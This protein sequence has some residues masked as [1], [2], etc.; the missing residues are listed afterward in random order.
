[1]K[2][3][4][5]PNG[6]KIA[7]SVM[8]IKTFRAATLQEGLR[9]IHEELGEDVKIMHTREVE[10]S[11]LF[12]FRRQR[13][14]EI[15]VAENYGKTTQQKT[16]LSTEQPLP[17]NPYE[18]LLAPPVSPCFRSELRSTPA[19]AGIQTTSR[20]AVPLG[21][22]HQLTPEQLNPTVL[23]RSLIALFTESVRFGGPIDLLDGK[24]K[25]VAFLGMSGVGKTT[26]I[27]KIAAH[28][29]L[30]EF[31]RVGLVT[32][33]TFR[34][35]AT[36][37]LGKYAEMLGLPMEIVSEPFRMKTALTRLEACD[38]ILLDTPGINPKNTMKLQTLGAMLDAAA[39]D[40][41]H[42]LFSATTHAVALG[43]MFHRFEPLNPTDLTFTKL[44][45]AVGLT[46]LYQFLK[47]N[48]L[49]LRF[50]SLGQ[51]ISEDIEVAGPAR[52]ASLAY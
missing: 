3:F 16:D 15:T 11:R 24:R 43:E 23:Q 52:L 42:L 37:Q 17:A 21:V 33:D 25:T 49:P 51:N 26:T 30:K 18:T 28:Y 9:Q 45:E 47:T 35:A 10:T 44:D 13:F 1:V 38:L 4:P 46:D 2:I 32:I 34:V 29:R 39:V 20:Q 7:L 41:V 19:D 6:Y 22:W 31:K 27:A 36:E 48:I 40:E 14:F 5:D 12:G 50:F 8:N